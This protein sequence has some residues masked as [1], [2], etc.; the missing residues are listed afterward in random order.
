[1]SKKK[2]LT[3]KQ[4]KFAQNVASGMRKKDAAIEAGYSEKNAV[5]A[6]AV[7]SSDSNP[8]VKSRIN[9]LQ[10]KAASKVELK[11]ENHLVDLKDI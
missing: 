5:R 4:E 9:Q 3:P 11:L 8:L 6:G 2:K 7:L 1:M 10:T